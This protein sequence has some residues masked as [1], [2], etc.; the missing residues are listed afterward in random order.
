MSDY[1]DVHQSVMIANA[2]VESKLDTL[3]ETVKKIETHLEIQSLQ[4]NNWWIAITGIVIGVLIQTAVF[5]YW[6][7]QISKQIEVDHQNI[8]E[9]W[10]RK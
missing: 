10:N 9:L 2:K 7:G 1:C 8:Q 5:C 6:L 3:V 4:R